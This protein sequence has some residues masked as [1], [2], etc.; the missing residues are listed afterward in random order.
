MWTQAAAL[1]VKTKVSVATA[2]LGLFDALA[3]TVLSHAEHTKSTRP[4]TILCVYLLFSS[5]FDAVQ[6]RTLWLLHGW[7]TLVAVF[8]AMLSVKLVMLCLE[9][10]NKRS[11]LRS[12]WQHM[13]P[14]STSG[15]FNRGL[16][17]WLNDLL[18]RGF[19]TVLLVESL[20]PTD[21]K[22]RSEWLLQKLQIS[23]K[24][25][26]GRKN[27]AL[28]IS[29]LASVKKTLIIAIFPRLCLTGFKF[30]QPFLIHRVILF[31]A[32]P[33]SPESKNVAY[34]LIGATALIYIGIAVSS[35]YR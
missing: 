20:Y 21:K 19:Q 11:F 35:Y 15:I 32:Q 34:G 10:Q 29:I 5:T 18:K 12:A 1:G 28:L 3:L 13:G 22:L 16:F 30:A 4:S 7:S 6:C 25:H 23:W 27:N 24:T 2:G 33:N 8:T 17:W 31:I 26:N 9:G 14:E